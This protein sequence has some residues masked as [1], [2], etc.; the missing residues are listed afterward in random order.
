MMTNMK[1]K[2]HVLSVVVFGLSLCLLPGVSWGAVDID[3]TFETGALPTD[4]WLHGC[5]R[6]GEPPI[7]TPPTGIWDMNPS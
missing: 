1:M 7:S 6:H 4:V 2:K 5:E 3:I